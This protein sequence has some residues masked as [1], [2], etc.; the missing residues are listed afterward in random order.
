MIIGNY[1]QIALRAIQ[2]YGLSSDLQDGWS[3][4]NENPSEL[5]LE[6]AA[7]IAGND[8]YD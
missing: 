5:T 3:A 1:H 6:L 4:F 7:R 2:G 8:Q